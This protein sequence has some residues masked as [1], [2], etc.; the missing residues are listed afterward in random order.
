MII[1]YSFWYIFSPKYFNNAWNICLLWWTVLKTWQST[2]VLFWTARFHSFTQVQDSHKVQEFK[3]FNFLLR[4][5]GGSHSRGYL[6][7][8]TLYLLSIASKYTFVRACM[9]G[10]T[11]QVGDQL[12]SRKCGVVTITLTHGNDHSTLQIWVGCIGL[13]DDN[14]KHMVMYTEYQFKYWWNI[15]YQISEMV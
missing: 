10:D 3:R 11:I 15:S 8:K 12:G 14:A 6:P 9:K 2:V 13:Y 5:H 7:Y 1:Q 4:R